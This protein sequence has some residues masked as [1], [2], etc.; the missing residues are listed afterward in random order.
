LACLGNS[1]HKISDEDHNQFKN[2]AIKVFNS[3]FQEYDFDEYL[4]AYY[5]HPNYRGKIILFNLNLY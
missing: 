2:Y 1:I 3:R 4:L 5:L